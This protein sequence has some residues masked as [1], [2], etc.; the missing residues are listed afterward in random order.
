M[1]TSIIV[2]VIHMTIG[3]L[4][5]GLN[6]I[7]FGDWTK[8]LFVFIPELLFFLCT[9]GYMV[10]LIIVKWFSVFPS[11]DEA[12]SIISVFINLASR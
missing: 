8:F 3:I 11:P 1:K 9:F 5:K 6:C 10:I 12:P 7:Y 4:I 2:G